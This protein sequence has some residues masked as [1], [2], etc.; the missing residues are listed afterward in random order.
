MKQANLNVCVTD[1]V[2]RCRII[3]AVESLLSRF[4]FLPEFA[5]LK[6][7]PSLEREYY[8]HGEEKSLL[9]S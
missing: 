7:F 9:K 3:A 5:K 4:L 6:I 2:V 1:S 8:K